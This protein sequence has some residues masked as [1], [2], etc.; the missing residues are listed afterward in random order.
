MELAG[1]GV[2]V[3]DAVDAVLLREQPVEVGG[4]TITLR[5]VESVP[6]PNYVAQR[7]VFDVAKNGEP[8]EPALPEKRTYVGSPMVTTEAAIQPTLWGDLYVVLGDADG[9]GGYAVRAYFKPF[10]H[11][12]WF[13]A[14]FMVF[15]GVVSLS[16]RRHRVGAPR[17][18]KVDA[19]T[20]LKP[21]V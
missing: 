15:G 3:V 14:A 8:R 21:A 2:G 19:G 4:Y 16:D 12:M 6:G 7:G 1:A 5:R 10:V 17:L 11:W 18:A 9:A 13:G 20:G